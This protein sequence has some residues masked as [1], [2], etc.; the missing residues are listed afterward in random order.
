MLRSTALT[1]G[2]EFRRVVLLQVPDHQF[3]AWPVEG[4]SLCTWFMR[5]VSWN[6]NGGF[7]R[8]AERLVALKPSVAVVQECLRTSLDGLPGQ[9]HWVGPEKKGL[10]VV[11]MPPWH[12]RRSCEAC[13]YWITAAEIDGPC[14]FLVLGVWACQYGD[15][16]EDRYIGQVYKAILQH[17]EWFGDLPVVMAG[18]FNSNSIWDRKRHVANHTAV[19]GL[20]EQAGLVS[21][22]HHF[23]KQKQGQET[24]PTQFLYRHP[25][26][27][28]HIDY[29]F[30]PKTWAERLSVVKVG[31][32][33]KW[34][35][36]SDH[37]PLIV[38]V[39]PV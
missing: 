3:C 31:E 37:L 16:P 26:R 29:I 7:H 20:L 6:A 13:G 1:P 15:C 11:A 5:L 14:R 33:R 39:D 34:L 9:W 22:Y 32:R 19:V 30:I 24:R 21:A 12:I 4:F 17:P 38:D 2:G 10:A 25:K 27:G 28:F 35:S 18:D 8:K 23:F 36:L